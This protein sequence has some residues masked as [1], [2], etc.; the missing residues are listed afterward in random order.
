MD[1]AQQPQLD[2]ATPLPWRRRKMVRRWLVAVLVVLSAVVWA[3]GFWNRVQ[4]LWWQRQCLAYVA[5]ADQVVY[6]DGPAALQLLSG[7][8]MT[9]SRTVGSS[10]TM[11]AARTV[12]CWDGLKQFVPTGK[13]GA[14]LYLHRGRNASGAERLIVVEFNYRHYYQLDFD[15]WDLSPANPVTALGLRSNADTFPMPF[16]AGD[17]PLRF[18]AGQPDPNDPTRFTI[19]YDLDGKTGTIEGCVNDSGSVSLVAKDGPARQP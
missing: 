3:P 14:L 15:C 2:Y 12:K 7:A 5:P 11:V 4:V 17:K 8:G 13:S 9:R 19:R 16:D 10:R 6:D 1:G 18:Y